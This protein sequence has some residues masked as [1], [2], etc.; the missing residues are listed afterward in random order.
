MLT[1]HL[2]QTIVMNGTER[3]YRAFNDGGFQKEMSN[4]A[5]KYVKSSGSKSREITD[6][7]LDMIQG[8]GETFLPQAARYPN[9]VRTYQEL[10]RERLPFKGQYDASRVPI[11]TPPP[12]LRGDAQLVTHLDSI[13]GTEW[14]MA[15]KTWYNFSGPLLRMFTTTLR[16]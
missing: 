9:I 5:R 8:W 1:L 7:V 14:T 13:R 16:A 3:I 10:R 2:C 4:V 15:L 6:L 12:L 11:L